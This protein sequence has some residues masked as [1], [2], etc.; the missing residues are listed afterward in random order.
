MKPD[1]FQFIFNMTGEDQSIYQEFLKGWTLIALSQPFVN[2]EKV[3][4]PLIIPLS[5]TSYP[6]V[7]HSAIS[8]FWVILAAKQNLE[9]I[10]AKGYLW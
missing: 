10:K 3:N 1:K 6:S 4:N 8:C 2:T 7:T 5:T 9:P